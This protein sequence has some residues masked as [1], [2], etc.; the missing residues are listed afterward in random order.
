MASGLPAIVRF[1]LHGSVLHGQ[2]VILS[3]SYYSG[4]LYTVP[5]TSPSF[6]TVPNISRGGEMASGLTIIVRDELH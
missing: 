4:Q 3:P 1:E 6:I 2:Y 5:D